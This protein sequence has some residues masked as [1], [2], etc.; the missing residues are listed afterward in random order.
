MLSQF[1][2]DFKDCQNVNL[3]TYYIYRLSLLD[4]IHGNVFLSPVQEGNN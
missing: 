4:S 1:R 2:K 3:L